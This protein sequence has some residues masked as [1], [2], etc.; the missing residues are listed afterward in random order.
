[1]VKE[2]YYIIMEINLLESG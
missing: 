2:K 1:M